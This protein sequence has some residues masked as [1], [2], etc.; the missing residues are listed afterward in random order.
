M[1]FLNEQEIE[2]QINK[3]TKSRKTKN[4]KDRSKIAS[5]NGK[6]GKKA[7]RDISKI[8]NKHSGQNFQ[9]IIGSGSFTGQKNRSR[10]NN[11]TKSQLQN[12]LGDIC[13]PETLFYRFIIESKHYKSFPWKKYDAGFVPANLKKWIN[14]IQF[15]IETYV[16]AKG[17]AQEHFGFLVFRINNKGSYIVS[18]VDYCNQIAPDL[19][20]NI[21]SYKE[22]TQL[23]FDT[24]KNVGYGEKW[25]ICDFEKFVTKNKE[26]LF[27]Q[28][29]I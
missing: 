13:P 23:P 1:A 14:E 11:L 28:I 9:R 7:E 5:A 16:I 15:D 24:L 6:K 29:E 18:N 4:G 19:D 26:I 25:F 17:N 22:I 8:L 3:L 20:Y 2:N 10:A 12:S 21:E 27:R